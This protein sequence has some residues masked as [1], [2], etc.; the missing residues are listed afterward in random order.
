V[1]DWRD[2][3]DPD[4]REALQHRRISKEPLINPSF[5]RMPESIALHSLDPGMRR[6][7]EK[8]INQK[9]PKWTQPMLATLTDE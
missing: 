1:P 4:S 2:D 7:D 9:I 6:D 5:R 3:L 8:R